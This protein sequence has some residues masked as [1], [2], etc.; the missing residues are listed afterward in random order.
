MVQLG[1]QAANCTNGTINW[2]QIY[3]EDAFR[4][5]TPLYPSDY[6]RIAKERKVDL[7][8]LE[9]RARE[10]AKVS[11]CLR[12]PACCVLEQALSQCLRI[13]AEEGSCCW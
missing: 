6:D 13:A 12:L 9:K 4:L 3:G 7:P 5:K 8:S 10:F 11:S 2:K 1:H